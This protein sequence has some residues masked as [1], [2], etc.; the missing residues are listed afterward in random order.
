MKTRRFLTRIAACVIAASAIGVIAATP[1]GIV[2]FTEDRT[3][4]RPNTDADIG[5]SG[6]PGPGW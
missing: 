4:T 3:L 2:A 6:I 5:S 1:T